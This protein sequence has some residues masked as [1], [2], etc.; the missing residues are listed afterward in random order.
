MNT[1]LQN[2]LLKLEIIKL[3]KSFGNENIINDIS[4]KVYKNE[5]I[6]ILGPSGCGKSTIFNIIAGLIK[7]NSG[8]V[9]VDGVDTTGT[10]GVV[11]YMHQKDLLMP[12]M[13]IID[14]AALPLVIKGMEKQEAKQMVSKHFKTFGLAGC[15][16]K[17]PQMLSG[18][19]RQR[20]ALLRTYMFSNNLMLL[21][22]PFGALDAIT[23]S[24]MQYWLLDMASNLK[25]TIIF[26]THDI[27]EAVLLSNRIYV[28]SDKPATVKAEILVEL[29]KLRTRDIITS[30]KFNE[31]KKKIIDN[32]MYN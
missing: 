16:E 4:L 7:P 12:W 1:Y 13:K 30:P 27:E 22:E 15:E 17:Y 18:G 32:L 28:L 26:I 9:I 31:I 20:A 29:P 6:S 21:D 5:F 14:N 25:T 3:T 19:M 8:N 24:K 23:R 2:K 11:S 10:A